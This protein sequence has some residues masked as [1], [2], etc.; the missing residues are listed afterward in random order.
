M[1]SILDKLNLSPQER[2]LVVIVA[3][4]VFIVLNV[5]LIWPEFGKVNFWT[6]KRG[7]ALK[8]LQ[9][10]TD[11]VKKRTVYQRQLV[12]LEDQ[13]QFTIC[14]LRSVRLWL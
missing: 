8:D 11:E 9:K 13:G 3:I 10:F 6:N 7:G 2:R 1:T 14:N 5:W 4:V 12:E